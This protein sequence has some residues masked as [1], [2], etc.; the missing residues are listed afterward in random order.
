MSRRLLSAL[1]LAFGCTSL[2]VPV[3]ASAQTA[4]P[5]A[6]PA[7]AAAAKSPPKARPLAKPTATATATAAATATATPTSGPAAPPAAAPSPQSSSQ[8]HAPGTLPDFVYLRD[9]YRRDDQGAALRHPIVRLKELDYLLGT[10]NAHIYTLS[11]SHAITRDFGH[12]TYVFARTMRDR[13]IL[14]TDAKNTEFLYFTF[15]P[16]ANH[17][18]FADLKGFPSCGI[19]TATGT[20]RKLVFESIVESALGDE[21]RIRTTLTSIDAKHV[22]LLEEEETPNDS[23]TP[24]VEFDFSRR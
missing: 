14:G 13:W 20:G 21:R 12:T 3:A 17:W 9:R 18:V 6:T 16:P 19:G 2:A 7:D 4:S 5:S 11:Q 8:S 1:A 22:S 24:V 15:D 23:F 10:W